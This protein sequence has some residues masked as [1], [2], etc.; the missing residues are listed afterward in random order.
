MKARAKIAA[1]AVDAEPPQVVPYWGAALL[2]A[3]LATWALI[4]GAAR[5]VAGL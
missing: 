3:S 4:I 2:A 5:L 1:E